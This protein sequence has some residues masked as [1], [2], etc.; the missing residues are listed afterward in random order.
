[1]N[2]S[3][4]NIIT[5]HFRFLRLF[6]DNIF[7]FVLFFFASLSSYFQNG[8]LKFYG[9]YTKCVSAKARSRT[10]Q[11][12]FIVHRMCNRRHRTHTH[13]TR[14]LTNCFGATSLH[15]IIRNSKE[16]WNSTMLHTR[17]FA[18]AAAAAAH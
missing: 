11:F 2:I 5:S 6:V 15:Y 4:D 8:K 1:M 3:L 18:V 7:N 12:N 13:T 10:W 16:K 17:L 14:L 9:N